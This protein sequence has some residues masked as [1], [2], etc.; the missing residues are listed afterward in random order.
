MGD[1]FQIVA[2]VEATE[3]EAPRL[4]ESVVAWL[5]AEQII[6]PGLSD[7]VLG[8]VGYAPGPRYTEALG[9]DPADSYR[10]PGLRYT[11]GT[12]PP[13]SM[14]GIAPNGVEVRV[15][16][17]VFS[18][19]GSGVENIT[20]PHCAAVADWDDVSETVGVWF[21]SGVGDHTC[22]ACGRAAGLN[23]WR[24]EPPWAFGYLGLTFWNWL[25]LR[26]SFVTELGARLGHRV[27]VVA[28]KL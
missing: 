8:T 25:P 23:E 10:V 21:A 15:G 24:F 1:W 12:A 27:V 4:A 3:E 16:R 20:C 2:D 11:E 9:R 19:S 14:L 6:Q 22:T 18:T 13:P 5:V 26:R 17:A 28:D 7:R